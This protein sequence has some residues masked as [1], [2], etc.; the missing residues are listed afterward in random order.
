M[1]VKIDSS[2]VAALRPYTKPYLRHSQE[3]WARQL[4][5]PETI[6]AGWGDMTA[7]EGAWR[8]ADR[9]TGE[10]WLIADEL[11][12]DTY[13][14]RTKPDHA[15]WIEVRKFVWTSMVEIPTDFRVDTL[16][17]PSSGDKG[18]F[19]AI[20]FKGDTWVVKGENVGDG[21]KYR[22]IACDPTQ[23]KIFISYARDDHSEVKNEVLPKG[24]AIQE[25]AKYLD[26]THKC[27]V[28]FD[29]ESIEETDEWLNHILNGI[30]AADVVLIVVGAGWIQND[31]VAR[32]REFPLALWA[33]VERKTAVVP[34]LLDVDRG[35]LPRSVPGF[36]DESYSFEDHHLGT[37]S[38]MDFFDSLGYRH[39]VKSPALKWS[40]GIWPTIERRYQEVLTE[41][42]ASTSE[43]IESILKLVESETHRNGSPML[44][45]APSP[46]QAPS[47]W[48]SPRGRGSWVVFSTGT[49]VRSA[50]VDGSNVV[51]RDANPS[52]GNETTSIAIGAPVDAAVAADD[53]SALAVLAGGVLRIV[54]C[55]STPHLWSAQFDL[56]APTCVPI[57]L[58]RQGR[59][60]TILW[61]DDETRYV[62]RLDSGGGIR[63]VDSASGG[64]QVAAATGGDFVGIDFDGQLTASPAAGVLM[65]PDVGRWLSIDAA[66][67]W[68]LEPRAHTIAGLF[69]DRGGDKFAVVADGTVARRLAVRSEAT[70]VAVARSKEAVP[71]WI[72][73]EAGSDLT[74]WR[75]EDLPEVT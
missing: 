72:V 26:R 60:Y 43:P 39:G 46:P 73:V 27:K 36:G 67:P 41:R 10:Q 68:T 14:S 70:R 34:V 15:G 58:R 63:L 12:A 3:L 48:R 38:F 37:K 22:P 4:T 21:K 19:L 57:A 29:L 45:E 33:N 1:G 28:F 25:L 44:P 53:G 69:E 13:A 47:K 56:P 24:E 62:S 31:G 8:I 18:D 71:E 9:A 6:K 42:A 50:A 7:E 40:Q 49:S 32:T 17:G 23:R 54:D 11:F 2:L 51:F 64:L 75:I 35:D 59:S 52:S 66:R 65:Q 55:G 20:G 61:S 30:A 74:G 5:D 16:E